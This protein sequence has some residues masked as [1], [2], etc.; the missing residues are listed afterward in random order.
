MIS[1]MYFEVLEEIKRIGGFLFPEEEV[2]LEE[3]RK[4]KREAEVKMCKQTVI[5]TF[6]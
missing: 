1:K 4:A 3:A 6:G 2:A 5:S